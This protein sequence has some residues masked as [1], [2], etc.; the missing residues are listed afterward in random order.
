[1]TFEGVSKPLGVWRSWSLVVGTMIGSAVFM[2]PSVLAPYGG[3]SLVGWAISAAGTLC[4]A[5]ALSALARRIPKIGGPYAYTLAAFGRLPAFLIAWGYWI[6]LWSAIAAISVAF[7][8][9]FGVFVPS[10][11]ASPLWQAAVAISATWILVGINMAG[12]RTAGTVQLVTTLLKLAPLVLISTMGLVAGDISMAFSPAAATDQSFILMMAGIV[13]LTMG[14]FIGVEA[15]TVPADDTVDPAKTIPRAL[16]W[17]TITA[18]IVYML[19]TAGVM[20]LVPGDALAASSSPFADAA[21]MLLGPGG[22]RL[23]AI[24]AMI[25]ILGALNAN[26]LL[27]GQMPRAAALDGLFPPV[28]SRL[29]SHGAPYASI[30][31]SGVV[32]TGLI[33]MN[34]TKGVVAAFQLLLALTTL[35]TLIPYAASGAAEAVLQYRER[36]GGQALRLGTLAAAG[37]A[38]I[39]S[40]FAILGSGI[41]TSIYGLLLFAAGLPIYAVFGRPRLRK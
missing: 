28:F 16:M 20:S 6:A 7:V 32:A 4:I 5:L 17:G 22:S 19:A 35:A 29:N 18:T 36:K 1:M 33:L 40:L 10:I 25:S 8:G 24:G 14:A 9:Y 30:L 13:I 27:S 26:V 2:L 12:L 38:V 15:A 34:Y 39:F 23:V 11:G 3:L 37:G 21:E 31:V 41:E